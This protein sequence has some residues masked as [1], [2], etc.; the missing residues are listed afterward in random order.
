MD[1][2]TDQ[3]ILDRFPDTFVDHDNKEFYRGWLQRRLLLNR[4]SAC[5]T[6][7]H[8]PRPVCPKCWSFDVVPTEASG[9]GTVHLL[10]RLHQGPRAPGVDYS[11]PLPV[12]AVE[13]AEQ[14]GLRYTSSIVNCEPEDVH[15]DM[16]VTL[17][18]IERYGAPFP[19][20]EPAASG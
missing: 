1:I 2:V 5:G 18:W 19:V 7:H 6:W 8:P 10:V 12:V 9:R 17:T 3:E 16:P 4:C 11:K 15:I 20:F 14:V 13:L